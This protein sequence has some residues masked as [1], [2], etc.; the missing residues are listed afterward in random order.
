M[1]AV[2]VRHYHT[3]LF[4]CR[5]P[6][7]KQTMGTRKDP[8]LSHRENAFTATVN[9]ACCECTF[10]DG[11]FFNRRLFRAGQPAAH[12]NPGA[13]GMEPGAFVFARRHIYTFC[14][15]EQHL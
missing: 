9:M 11:S 14:K 3:I 8:P 1:A 15:F 12:V 2:L 4:L 6:F 5:V 7:S 13:E 10:A